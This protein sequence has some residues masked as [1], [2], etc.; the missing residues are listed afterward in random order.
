MQGV[1]ATPGE[2][3]I[4]RDQ[5]LHRRNLGGE[6]DAVLRQADLFGARG[7][8]HRRLH[9]GL[10]HHLARIERLSRLGVFVH[11]AREQFLIE[12][13][14]VG[15]DAHRLVV[16]E[17]H[18]DDGGELPVPLVLEADIAGIDAIFAERLGAAGMIGQQLVTDVVE[19]A[20]QRHVHAKLR[21]P[22]PD[23]RHCGSRLVAVDRDAHELRAGRGQRSHLARG[24]LDIGGVG[25]G[26]RLHDDRRAAAND[27]AADIHRG[28]SMALLRA[29]A[30]R[31]SSV[32]G[33]RQISC[34]QRGRKGPCDRPY[35][36][37]PATLLVKCDLNS[38]ISLRRSARAR[39][40]TKIIR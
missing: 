23:V 25:I 40:W 5:V 35:G 17:R 10:V 29:G 7:R 34:G 9:H 39:Q 28:R 20:D 2:F 21:K 37:L 33:A 16:F 8:Q 38:T 30:H 19:I 15:A 31:S 22:V 12:R 24:A 13:T 32:T 6:Y 1:V 18:L 11:Q 26:H 14:P 3:A 4:D 36:T 27:D